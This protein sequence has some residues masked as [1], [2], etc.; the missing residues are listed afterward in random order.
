M[1]LTLEGKTIDQLAIELIQAY[2]VPDK[3]FYGGFSGGVDSQ[4]IYDL[5]ERAEVKV[6][7]YYNE[8]PIDPLIIRDFIKTNY[9][10]VKFQNHSQ[11]FFSKHVLSQ[12]LPRR[13]QRWCCAL[14]KEC[15]GEGR[16]KILGMRKEESRGRSGYNCFMSNPGSGHWLLPIVNWT[17]KDRWQYLS[18]RGIKAN[19]LYSMGFKRTGCVLCPNQSKNDVALS[20][21]HFPTIV[22]LWR[23]AAEKYIHERTTNPKRKPL[24]KNTKYHTGEEYFNWWIKR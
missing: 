24:S 9:P 15:G 1:Q 7:W 13:K 22:R 3:P 4:C 18:E 16:V 19:P 23:I 2:Y 5:A 20:L 12:G 11:H 14:I 10:K 17:D 8:S 6:D 21:K